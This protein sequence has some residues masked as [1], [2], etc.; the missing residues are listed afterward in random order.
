LH[1]SARLEEKNKNGCGE[2][3]LDIRSIDV[4]EVKSAAGQYRGYT[5]G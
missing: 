5:G 4:T 1:D 3:P 2:H